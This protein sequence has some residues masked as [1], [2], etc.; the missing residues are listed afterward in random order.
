[1]TSCADKAGVDA[2][3]A[4][5]HATRKDLPRKL[6]RLEGADLADQLR[7]TKEAFPAYLKMTVR[8]A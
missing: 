8:A 2:A 3:E 5:G 6:A 1:M 7:L 4:L